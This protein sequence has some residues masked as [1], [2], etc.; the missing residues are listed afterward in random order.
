MDRV[1]AREKLQAAVGQFLDLR[2]A[3]DASKEAA[4]SA[5]I[6]HMAI[7]FVDPTR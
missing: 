2:A 1:A 3:K 4:V 7:C 6:A 5:S